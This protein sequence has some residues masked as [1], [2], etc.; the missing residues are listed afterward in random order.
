MREVWWFSFSST[1]SR[2]VSKVTEESR[3]LEREK[4]R[5]KI[6]EGEEDSQNMFTGK[7]E[8]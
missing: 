1:C 2:W 6:M 4:N 8:K 7:S 5:G 3:K